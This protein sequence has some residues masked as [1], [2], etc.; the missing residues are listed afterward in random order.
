M[1][2][3]YIIFF[4]TFSWSISITGYIKNAKTGKSIPNA[5]IIVK[6]TRQGVASDPYG[7]FKLDE[8]LGLY[9]LEVSV[10]GFKKH[11]E[12]INLDGNKEVL[13][14]L[15]STVLEY[16]EVQVKGLFDTRMGYESV[17]IIKSS[18]IKAMNKE[19]FSD[20]LKSLKGVD[21][22]FSHPNGRNVNIS[23]RGSSDYKPGGYNNRVLVL[24]DGLPILIPN[25]GS[26]DWSSLPIENIKRIELNN[27]AAST[28]Y[29]H[30]SMGGVINLV[31][32]NNSDKTEIQILGGKYG[33]K[34]IGLVYNKKLMSWLYGTSVMFRYSEGHRYNAD[35]NIGRL[36]TFLKYSNKG[37]NYSL[38]YLFSSSNLGHPGFDIQ[39]SNKYRRS[40]RLSQYIQMKGFYPITTGLSMSHSIFYNIF[41]TNYSNRNDVPDIWLETRSLDPETSYNDI[42]YGIRSEMMITKYSRWVIMIGYDLDWSQSN[43][44]LLNQM[45]D[46]PSQTTFGSFLQS[47][48]SIG[49][50]FY[51]NTGIRF[52]YRKT[53]PGKDF[54]N[55]IYKNISP[56]IN[57][58][59]KENKSTFN[60]SY[61]K[62][63]RAPSISEL[64]LKHTTTYGL[65]VSGNPEL[66][67]E[68]VN[69]YEIAY[70]KKNDNYNWGIELFH[71]R[72]ENM[73][74]FVYDVP[75]RAKNRKGIKASGLDFNYSVILTNYVNVD[76]NYSYLDMVDLN[77]DQ[78]LYRSKHKGKL[79]INFSIYSTNLALGAQLQSKQYYE[80][81]LDTF[82]SLEGFPIKVLPSIMIPEC[83]ISKSF[84]TYK[85]SF[86]ISNLL[87]QKYELIQNYTMPGRS[88][89]LSITKKIY[90]E[91]NE[92]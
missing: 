37:R 33:T 2:Y 80:D 21:S 48:Y 86:R 56:K 11:I 88:W 82:N 18:D 17:D 24:L 13:I 15:Y 35:Y 63:F 41:K 60:I 77:G 49:S 31:T 69:S 70:K 50:G 64:Y 74:D 46:N 47:Q 1:K 72:Y 78:V 6:E 20:I 23:I 45:Y 81:F 85:V 40:N 59:K 53:N 43:V 62:G 79:F 38:N 89:Q 5:N 32:D 25:S 4:I 22:Q 61:S 8:K 91:K 3:F 87:D 73:I 65:I 39:N 34:K 14:N 52:D 58:S 75:T 19:S 27:A 92:N 57:I 51:L 42:N 9:T 29:G 84:E 68:A 26:P 55:R 66:L 36:N 71:S 16:D 7:F 10:I 28:Q 76:L 90:K 44:D 30:N 54:Q 67:P 83:I 12:E